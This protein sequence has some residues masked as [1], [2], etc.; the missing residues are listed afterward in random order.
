M[1]ESIGSL[2]AG[3]TPQE[4]QV[5]CMRFG[6]GDGKAHT[7]KEVGQKFSVTGEQI[8]QVEAKALRKLRGALKQYEGNFPATHG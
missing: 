6:I 7:L 1:I 2:I 8:R 4:E 5:V 3:I